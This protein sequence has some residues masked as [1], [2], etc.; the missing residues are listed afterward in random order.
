MAFTPLNRADGKEISLPVAAAGSLVKDS[1]AK[2]S[3]GYLVVGASGDNEVEYLATETVAGNGTNGGV[4][5][6]VIV[7]D[8]TIRI[9]ALCDTT[10]VQATHVGLDVDIGTAGAALDLTGTTDKVFH[11][12]SIYSAAN[13]L[14]VGHFNKPGL[15]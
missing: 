12:D 4:Y 6:N 14:V 2:M 10:P 1:L 15:A 11:I 9:L 5:A 7:L 3:S 8:E 13:K